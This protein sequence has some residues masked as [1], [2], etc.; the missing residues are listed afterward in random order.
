M[1]DGKL[2]TLERRW[3]QTGLE[4]DNARFSIEFERQ[5]KDFFE[6][7]GSRIVE[8]LQREILTYFSQKRISTDSLES[9]SCYNPPQPELTQHL[10]EKGLIKD[11]DQ[12]YIAGIDGVHQWIGQ[13]EPRGFQVGIGPFEGSNGLSWDRM[14]AWFI[15]NVGKYD[16]RKEYGGHLKQGEKR[17]RF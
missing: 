17:Y 15:W 13:P 2:R 5:G 14:Y 11:D 16:P 10:R 4:E 1:A 8:S 9:L 3:Y 6:Y 12:V 7:T